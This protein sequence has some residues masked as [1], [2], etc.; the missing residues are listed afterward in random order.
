MT[1]GKSVHVYLDDESILIAK[2]LGDENASDG[3][4]SDGIRRALREAAATKR[5]KKKRLSK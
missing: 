3:N 4:V 2:A 5:E 1:G